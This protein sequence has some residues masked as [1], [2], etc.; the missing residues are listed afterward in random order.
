MPKELMKTEKLGFSGDLGDTATKFGAKQVLGQKEGAILPEAASWRE[1]KKEENIFQYKTVKGMVDL[2]AN[3]NW[4]CEGYKSQIEI[5]SG[6][7]GEPACTWLNCRPY[8]A[9]VFHVPFTMKQHQSPRR[10]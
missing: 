9:R 8:E 4:S 5:Q 10:A 6:F 2:S 7:G 3:E 1:K